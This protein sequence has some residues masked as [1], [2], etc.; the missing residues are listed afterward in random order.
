MTAAGAMHF[1]AGRLRESALLHW[2]LV[3]LAAMLLTAACIGFGDGYVGYL[4]KLTAIN[5][6]VVYG[7]NLLIGY[8]GQAFIAV[9]AIFAV[10]AYVSA[11]AVLQGGL[12]FVL[13]WA[14]AGLG[15]GAF[16]VVASMP[17]LR[18][19]GAYLA[20]VSIA[21]N[22]VIEQG[23]V[24]GPEFMGGAVGL[25]SIPPVEIA[26]VTFDDGATAALLAVTALVCAN[27]IAVLRR[28]QWGRAMVAMRDSEIAARSLGINVVSLKAAVFFVSSVMIGLAGG[29]Y[30]PAMAYISPDIGTIFASVVYVLMLIVGGSDTVLG[31]LLGAAALT[32]LP[33]L[34]SQF[35]QYHLIVLGVILLA[36]VILMPGGIVAPMTAWL[37]R[38]RTRGLADER[39][40]TDVF[41]FKLRQPSQDLS[42]RGISK[43]F[44]GVHALQDVNLTAARGLISGLIGPNGSG[45]ST[46]VNVVAGFYRPDSGRVLCGSVEVTGRST[47]LLAR[48]GIVRT[49]QTPHLFPKMTVCENLQVAQFHA[50]RPSLVAAL[51]NLP[52]SARSNRITAF[53]ARE[54][55]RALGLER[56]M[57][58]PAGKLSQGDQRRVEIARALVAE[59]AVLILDEPAV[60]LSTSEIERLCELLENLRRA[61][62]TMVLIEHHMDMVMRLCDRITVLE[63]GK[64]IAEGTPRE[65]RENA[66]VR[67]AYLGTTG[68]RKL[69]RGGNAAA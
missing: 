13:A 64:V 45:K 31:P 39:P 35:Q 10:G 42:A 63:R 49:F 40:T 32:V 25:P 65:I 41:S 68:D 38:R 17:A 24:H 54:V 44:G 50:H 5:V 12:P 28:S 30:S 2:L 53:R 3:G 58:E 7:L 18:L 51:L 59:P 20:M 27:C 1:A 69:E 57:N 11:L 16:G 14:L 26:G 9:A 29:L 34:L 21:L 66:D 22:V 47:A 33:Q 23:L 46:L 48:S 8:A 55:I 15:A 62:L 52:S 6:I 19:S 36:S 56:V 60:G 43:S 61:G 4:V 67:R 37:S